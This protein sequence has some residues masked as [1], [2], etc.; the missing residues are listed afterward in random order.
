CPLAVSFYHF[1]IAWTA[2]LSFALESARRTR[3]RRTSGI[4]GPSGVLLY[5]D[6][7]P[8]FSRLRIREREVKHERTASYAAP[9][10]PDHRILGLACDLCRREAPDRGPPGGGPAVGRGDRRGRGRGAPAAVPAPPRPGQRRRLRTGGRREIPPQCPGAAP[11]R[12][13]VR[14]VL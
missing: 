14:F 11:P 5:L 6:S 3:S 2:I 10:Q 1:M 9:P 12:G 7:G 13:G 4:G 8:I